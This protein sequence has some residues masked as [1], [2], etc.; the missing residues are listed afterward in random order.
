MLCKN[1]AETRDHLFFEC[2]YSSQLWE[3]LTLGILRS[4][5]SNDWAAIVSLISDNSRGVKS[6]F[7]VKYSF[8]AVVYALWREMNRIKHGEKPM[9]IT[10]LH[11][12]VDKGVRNKRSLVKMQKGRSM[13]DGLQFLFGT[14]VEIFIFG[15]CVFLR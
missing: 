11:K 4:A 13:A 6:T 2:A 7:C 14:R 15:V 12:L 8:Q 10:M 3:H 5:H 1:A 9:A